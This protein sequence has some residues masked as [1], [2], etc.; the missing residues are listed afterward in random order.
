[1]PDN[2]KK[3]KAAESLDDAAL[4]DVVGG[5]G[6]TKDSTPQPPPPPGWAER[7][8]GQQLPPPGRDP[9]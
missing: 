2:E 4:K 3:T 1:M 5:T 8:G 9:S 6:N 7:T